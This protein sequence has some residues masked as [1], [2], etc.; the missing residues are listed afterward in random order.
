MELHDDLAL[1]HGAVRRTHVLP[2]DRATA[3]ALVADPEGLAGWVADEVEIV[4][5]PGAEGRLRDGDEERTVRIED[6]VEGR[7]VAFRW[8]RAD[9]D[10]AHGSLVEIGL[11]DHP[12]G[13]LL[14]IL[15]LPLAVVEAVAALPVPVLRG[16]GGP[17][18]LACR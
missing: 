18:L 1:A 14:T 2:L 17:T 12:D 3:W 9:G 7:R 11:D 8:W 5:R 6:V 13:T 10:E 16:A 4:V 15:E